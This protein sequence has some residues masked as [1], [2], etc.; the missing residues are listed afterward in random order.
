MTPNISLIQKVSSFS[1]RNLRNIALNEEGDIGL[2][3]VSN[4]E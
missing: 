1:G 4:S 2:V 3:T